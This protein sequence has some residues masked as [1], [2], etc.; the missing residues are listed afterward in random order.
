MTISEIKDAPT[1]HNLRRG[2][3]AMSEPKPNR[4]AN[5]LAREIQKAQASLDLVLGHIAEATL[6]GLND[7]AG[8]SSG[9]GE[10][11]GGTRDF[12]QQ[13]LDKIAQ[14]EDDE[15]R[16]HLAKL[17]A[18]VE[19]ASAW[20]QRAWK[21]AFA[22]APLSVDK[23]RSLLGDGPS[24]CGNISCGR[25]VWR[26]PQDRLRAGR[27][28]PCYRYWQNHDRNEERPKSLCHPEE[29]RESA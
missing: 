21:E 18:S 29:R 9:G 12:T 22:L 2:A 6:R 20:A 26:T 8:I 3:I 14:R 27:C 7:S 4:V 19:A 11:V 23:A 17:V 5:E 15:T 13:I 1:N 25:D 28:E 24:K 10:P 16:K